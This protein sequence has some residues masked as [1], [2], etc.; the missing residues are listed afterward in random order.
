MTRSLGTL[1]ALTLSLTAS[2]GF[3]ADQREEAIL[4][5][6]RAA[7]FF[8]NDVA[9]EGGYVYRYSS[10]LKHRQGEGVAG[11]LTI[12]IQ[13]PGT[14][15]VGEAF[16]D[17]H[18]ATGDPFYLDAAREAGE[19][20]V[21]GQLNSGGWYYR[22]E[23]D[24]AKRGEFRYRADRNVREA[25]ADRAQRRGDR[26]L[27]RLEEAASTRT[28]SP[29]LTTTR[30]LPPSGSSA[31]ST[32]SSTIRTG[33]QR[34]RALRTRFAVQCAAS[35]RCLVAQLRPLPPRQ[36]RPDPLSDPRGI[37]SGTMVADLD[38]GLYRRL[39]DQRPR[40]AQ[41]DQDDARR[42]GCVQ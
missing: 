20:L 21:K 41:H 10:D 26:W 37:V 36:P 33:D 12:W 25:P 7:A 1:L 40:H 32:R 13:P 27:G 38:E 24:P 15:A 35:E 17:A 14:P 34:C 22:V 9:S 30:P 4:A 42:A 2:R 31:A 29:S 16:L 8:R 5:M 11:P 23:L 39:L 28:I 18:A 6:R 19:A 3:A